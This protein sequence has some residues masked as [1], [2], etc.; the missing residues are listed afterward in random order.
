MP[1]PKN[2]FDH[3]GLAYDDLS[4]CGQNLAQA[5]A[6]YIQDVDHG[7]PVGGTTGQVLEKNS[8]TD[9]DAGWHTLPAGSGVIGVTEYGPAMGNGY[10]ITTT[11]P[12][13][14][15]DAT[16]LIVT[17]VA[18][19]SGRVVVAL[20][21]II[22]VAATGSPFYAGLANAS[23][24]ARL[25]KPHE[26]TGGLAT[27]IL[28]VTPLIVVTGLTASQSYTAQLTAWMTSGTGTIFADD[29]VT[30]QATSPVTIVVSAA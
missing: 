27:G 8:N 21:A 22:R 5:V 18:P 13:T 26:L 1:G 29:G 25:G 23:G 16:N 4:D 24:G 19:A 15:V 14:P 30:G 17:F 10:T 3:S 28:S 12:D 6:P 20:N 7:L 11:S 2:S 9:Y